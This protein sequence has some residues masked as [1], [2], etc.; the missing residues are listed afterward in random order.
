MLY[1]A[2]GYLL[3][4][5]KNRAGERRLCKSFELIR[6]KAFFKCLLDTHFEGMVLVSA[7]SIWTQTSSNKP[8]LEIV[9]PPLIDTTAVLA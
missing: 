6:E 7:K 9:T 1:C 3:G 5:H 4:L 8:S 2:C